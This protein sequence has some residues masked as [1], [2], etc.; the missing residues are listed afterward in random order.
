MLLEVL[1]DPVDHGPLWYFAERA[2]LYNAR[3]RSAYAVKN[4]IP[5]M[6]ASEAT[7]LSAAEA[8]ELERT[9]DQAIETGGR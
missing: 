2:L 9:L 1:V 5:V 7:P 8:D 6:L 3:T 4:A